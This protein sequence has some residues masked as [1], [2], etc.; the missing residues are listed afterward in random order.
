LFYSATFLLVVLGVELISAVAALWFIRPMEFIPGL[1]VHN[2]VIAHPYRGYITRPNQT[3][4]EVGTSRGS[5]GGLELDFGL[6]PGGV[7]VD[8]FGHQVLPADVDVFR[9]P[10]RPGEFR[11]LF[12]GG[13]TTF[14]T[15]PF[16]VAE[17]LGQRG[18]GR[19]I[20]IIN[21]GTGGYTSQENV[22][23]LAVCGFA[24][25]PDLVVAYLPVNDIGYA[26]HWPDFRRDYTHMRRP[27]EVIAKSPPPGWA[28]RPFPFTLRLI[29]TL[30]HNRAMK[31]YIR[32]ADLTFG[33]THQPDPRLSGHDIDAADFEPTVAAVID[34]ALNM[35]AMCRVHGAVFM[36][37]TQKMFRIENP[38][39]SV[40][41][42]RTMDCAR[43][44]IASPLL[45]GV[46]KH[47]MQSIFPD[48]WDDEFR[49]RVRRDF[50][51]RHIDFDQ[52][53]AYDD[54]HFTPGGLFLF[55]S[56]IADFV[57]PMVSG[58]VAERLSPP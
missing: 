2:D 13:S 47:D 9:A 55:A 35:N 3:F 14:Q 21:A 41:Y 8:V 11:I 15:W 44:M 58:P 40:I 51:S 56:L 43:S 25:H 20:T 22:T 27:L 45:N 37:L 54:M 42:L 50:P 18:V 28:I 31:D 53:L 39:M 32:T 34:N 7:R 5:A 23:D 6:I 1:L 49:E 57:E 26:A 46:C 38:Y 36:L 30:V 52:P 24:Y 4:W 48:A 17:A 10:K 16:H 12:L 29:D 33:T 19:R